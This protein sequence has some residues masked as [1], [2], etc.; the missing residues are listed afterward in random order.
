MSP[1]E[2][3]DILRNAQDHLDLWWRDYAEGRSRPVT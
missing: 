1:E 3:E 2:L